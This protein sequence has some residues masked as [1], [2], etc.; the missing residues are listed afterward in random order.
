MGQVFYPYLLEK[1]DRD[2]LLCYSIFLFWEYFIDLTNVIQY[3]GGPIIHCSILSFNLVH[4]VNITIVIEKPKL[5]II[6][7]ASNII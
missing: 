1:V 4:D 2:F 7:T 3:K 6:T 5:N